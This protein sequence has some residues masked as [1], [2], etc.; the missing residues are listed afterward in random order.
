MKRKKKGGFKDQGFVAY[1]A[2]EVRERDSGVELRESEGVS[3]HTKHNLHCC[4][5]SSCSVL[6]FFPPF[7]CDVGVGVGGREGTF[8]ERLINM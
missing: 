1:V 6:L 3:G 7:C 8:D 5:S 2:G 4:C